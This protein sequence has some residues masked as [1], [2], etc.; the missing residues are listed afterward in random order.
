LPKGFAT[1]PA[2]DKEG[3]VKNELGIRNYELGMEESLRD[4]DLIDLVLTVGGRRL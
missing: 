4:G 2:E 3:M 1:E